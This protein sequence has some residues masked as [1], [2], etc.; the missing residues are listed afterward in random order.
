MRRISMAASVPAA[1]ACSHRSRLLAPLS[2]PATRPCRL[3]LHSLQNQA[4]AS[5][6]VL[7]QQGEGG[8]R[9]ERQE[10]GG[11]GGGTQRLLA[12]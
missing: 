2:S 4:A 6:Q 10:E 3:L 5:F 8:R 11:E 9:V 1:G 12:S 7:L